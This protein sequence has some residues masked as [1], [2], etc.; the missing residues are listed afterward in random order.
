MALLF[1]VAML[2]AGAALW[3]F[4]NAETIPNKKIR[5]PNVFSAATWGDL[6]AVRSF[7]ERGTDVNGRDRWGEPLISIAIGPKGKTSVV[8]YLLEKGAD[9]NPTTKFDT[10]LMVAAMWLNKPSVELLLANGAD[11]NGC[12]PDGRTAL[13]MVGASGEELPLAIAKILLKAGADPTL[14]AH[15]GHTALKQAKIRIIPSVPPRVER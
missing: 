15:D 5:H 1:G 4:A 6:K 9:P 11:P 2:L 14:T 13:M 10:P 12:A 3:F 8:R 7:I